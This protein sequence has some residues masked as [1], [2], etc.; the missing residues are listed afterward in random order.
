MM[1][2]VQFMSGKPCLFCLFVWVE[3]L[4]PSQQ[5][6]THVGMDRSVLLALHIVLYRTHPSNMSVFL[7]IVSAGIKILNIF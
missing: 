1:M 5:F 6:F 7:S 3:V 2:M 4:R